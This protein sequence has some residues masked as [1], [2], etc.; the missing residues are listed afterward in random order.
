MESEYFAYLK[1]RSRLG[2]I[3]RRFFISPV[4]SY[5]HGKVLDIGSGIGEFLEYY[6]DAVGVD[7]NKDCVEYCRSR[8]LDCIWADAYELPFSPGSFDGVFLNNVLEHLER[9]EDAFEEICRVLKENGSIC[10]EVPG[11]RGFDHDRTHVRFWETDDLTRLLQDI[12]F[13]EIRS[14]YFPVPFRW[15]G[16]VFTHNKLRVYATMIKRVQTSRF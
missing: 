16:R 12:G 2:K 10:I 7:L 5:F 1:K 9:P 8:Q 4:L 6:P 14:G 15:A 13:S 3:L 11:K